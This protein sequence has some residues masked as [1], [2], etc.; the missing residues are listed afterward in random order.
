MTFIELEVSSDFVATVTLNRPPVN[1]LGKEIR[2]ELIE[3]FDALGDREDVRAVILT[4]RGKIFC[5]GA[6]IKEKQTIGDAPGAYAGV[7][8]IIREAFYCI[9]E[10]RKPVI[11]AV[12]GAALGA[13]FC[14]A[15]CCDIL[16][17][18]EHAVFG[19]PEIDVGLAG[20]FGFLRRVL[21][22]SKVRRL[23]LTGERIPASEL[24][25]LGVLEACVPVEELLPAAME[26]ATR[27]AA[28]SPVAV[29]ML[30]ESFGTV[31]NLSLRDGYRLEQNATVALSKTADAREAQ[32]AFVEKRK[33]RFTG[34]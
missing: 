7:N 11:A 27:I 26:V 21:P 8:R 31:E 4:G 3:T 9:M 33:A 17:A 14:M 16:F 34:R 15:A 28:K 5:A 1:A 24:Y 12:N 20:G 19:M 30:K 2:L 6:D 22:Q 10:C 23:L 18:A 13:G 32:Q 25:R 29:G